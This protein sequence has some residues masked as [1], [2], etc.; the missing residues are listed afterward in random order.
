[1]SLDLGIAIVLAL[2]VA[3]LAGLAYVLAAPRKLTP[4]RPAWMDRVAGELEHERDSLL[5]HRE[6][7]ARAE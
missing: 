3:L 7:L 1:M 6:R 4:H 2:D 5:G